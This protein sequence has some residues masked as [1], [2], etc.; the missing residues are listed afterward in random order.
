[1]VF[2]GR[3]ERCKGAHTAIQVAKITGRKLII[4]GNISPLKE[5]QIYFEKEIQP[6]FDDDL[7]TYIGV[8]DNQQK[9][10]LLGSAAAMLLPVEW[11][12]PFPIVLPEAYACGTPI[13]AFPGGG[14]PE[15]IFE[16]ITGYLSTSAEKMAEQVSL[17]PGL[18]R[19]RC[20]EIAIERY[21]DDKIAEDYL[22]IYSEN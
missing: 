21:S 11:Y 2:L 20:R 13:L 1:M 7:I 6:E 8:V 22:A 16:G 9:N 3:L 14:V 5:E 4:A 10:N 18:N 15:G 19:K 17:I 12:E